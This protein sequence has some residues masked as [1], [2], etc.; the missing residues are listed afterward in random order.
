MKKLTALICLAGSLLLNLSCEKQSWDE[1][2]MFHQNRS[3]GEHHGAGE[4][5]APKKGAAEGHAPAAAGEHA[6]AP[7]H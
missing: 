2:K 1:T 7:K 5:A 6:P 4:H 3:V